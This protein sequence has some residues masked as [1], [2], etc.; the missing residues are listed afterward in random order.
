MSYANNYADLWR[1]AAR[2]VDK[3]LQ[4]MKP[5]GLPPDREAIYR[6]VRCATSLKTMHS[7]RTGGNSATGLTW[8][9]AVEPQV[10]DVLTYLIRNRDRVV[11]RDDLLVAVWKGRINI[12]LRKPPHKPDLALRVCAARAVQGRPNPR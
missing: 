7:I 6:T 9:R 11:S 10:L 4:G 2:Y 5:V 8:W 1:R 3:I 12:A